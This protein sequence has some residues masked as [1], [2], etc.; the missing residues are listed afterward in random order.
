MRV[1]LKALPHSSIGAL[2]PKQD[3]QALET[4]HVF[5]CVPNIDVYSA[6]VCVQ[7]GLCTP[8]GSVF[9]LASLQTNPD[10][11]RLAFNMR[12][13][14]RTGGAASNSLP[15]LFKVFFILKL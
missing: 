13:Q 10:I 3:R 8:K 14:V 15:F 12:H 2:E 4:K 1:D 5:V 11:S 6:C 7:S 9:P